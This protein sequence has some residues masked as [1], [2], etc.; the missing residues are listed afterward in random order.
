MVRKTCTVGCFKC[1]LCVKNCPEKAIHMENGLPV[2]DYNLCKS[3]AVCV[4]KCP[5]HVFKLFEKGIYVPDETPEKPAEDKTPPAAK[6]PV[7]MK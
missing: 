3:H 6:E 4:A 7:E 5:S 1:E 2:I